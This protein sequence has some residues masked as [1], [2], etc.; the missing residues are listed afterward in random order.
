MIPQKVR[1]EMFMLKVQD[2]GDQVVKSKAYSVSCATVIKGAVQCRKFLGGSILYVLLVMLM[3]IA[4]TPATGTA[5][6]IGA[7]LENV[8]FV[9]YTPRSFS[10]VNGRTLP[11][12]S[13]GITKDLELLHRDFNGII[14]YSCSNGLDHLPEIA[15][16]LH[17]KAVILGI[18]DPK[19]ESEIQTAIR[20]VRQF[21]KTIAAVS[22][23]N[24]GIYARRYRLE[25]VQNTIHRLRK[26]L[27]S[28][29]LTTSEPF[30]LY[31]KPEYTAFFDQM[32]LLL[33][34]I[35]PIFEKWFKPADISNAVAF[36]LNVSHDLEARYPGKPLLVKETGLPSGPASQGFT[37]E[38][39]SAF[40]A[41]VLK[42]ITPSRKFTVSCF[43]AFD[44]P[45]KPAVIKEDYPGD[46]EQEGFWGFYTTDG[47]PKPV[48]SAI[49]SFRKSR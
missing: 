9:S 4:A 28:V 43:E 45:W 48:I 39:Q 7:V 36:V 35:H 23:G 29:P 1:N 26:E 8:R 31:L 20:L 42:Q 24:E 34:N 22:V 13:A 30:F 5:A 10:V 19:S 21:P 14:I 2:R 40:W 37:P 16:K 11:A 27:P 18:W 6:D 32:D 25:D 3:F 38:R 17:Y 49:Q 33:P 46:H 41:A 12:T 15:E 44:E 47:R